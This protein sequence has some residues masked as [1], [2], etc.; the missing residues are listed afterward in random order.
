MRGDV[1]AYLWVFTLHESCFLTQVHSNPLVRK[2]GE[3][4]HLNPTHNL[5]EDVSYLVAQLE[6]A[7]TTGGVHLQG[8]VEFV[9]KPTRNELKARRDVWGHRGFHWQIAMQPR[10]VQENYCTKLEKDG[11]L[12]RYNMDEEPL[13]I[14][15]EE[16]MA[17][18]DA[19]R[20]EDPQPDRVNTP[21]RGRGGGGRGRAKD[22]TK[23]KED[24]LNKA[25]FNMFLEQILNNCF[26]LEH[27]YATVMAA[28]RQAAQDK[29]TEKLAVLNWAHS[30]L[31][32][33]GANYERIMEQRQAELARQRFENVQ[34]KVDVNVWWGPPGRGKS[35]TVAEKYADF[36]KYSH[37]VGS[38]GKWFCNYKGEVVL[39][40]DEFG[41]NVHRDVTAEMILTWLAGDPVYLQRK[42]K[43]PVLAQWHC[44][45]IISNYA[46]DQ[47]FFNF[48][49]ERYGLTFKAALKSRIKNKFH[50]MN[51]TEDFRLR[52]DNAYTFE[53]TPRPI[54]KAG[55]DELQAR[56]YISRAIDWLKFPTDEE[57]TT[58]REVEQPVGNA[59]AEEI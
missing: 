4:W 3:R 20:I 43:S 1:A 53:A 44:V 7:P 59:I 13:Q 14:A 35:T 21:G 31:T 46:F 17:V 12:Q 25:K 47:W 54:Q 49:D 30:K 40:L 23:R 50:H 57:A 32:M 51:G 19:A 36:S 5:G 37:N 48:S 28:M 42:G 24:L 38:D 39:V 45:A 33:S 41:R 10:D 56:P 55:F 9:S 11:K 16:K 58:V 6:N 26:N 29:D 18:V 2:M 15:D 8:S 27:A 52:E 22:E 34:R